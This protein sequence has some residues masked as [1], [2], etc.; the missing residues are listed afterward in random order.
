M[1]YM[2]HWSSDPETRH[3]AYK[4]FGQMSDAEDQADHPG[5]TLI[6]R[7]HDVVAGGGVLICESDSLSDVQ[8]WALNW[9]GIL[10]LDITPVVDD[11]ECKAM[12]KKK[13]GSS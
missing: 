1:K 8:A 3:D 11:D 9:N 4:T 7:W 13:W 5:V 2:M 10:D 12:L 6:G